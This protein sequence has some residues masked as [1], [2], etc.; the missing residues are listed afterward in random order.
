ML[1]E[2]GIAAL[3]V[4]GY[5]GAGLGGFYDAPIVY[6]PGNL[7]PLAH[8]IKKHVSVPVIAVGRISP[9]LAEE[10]LQDEKADFIAMGRPLLA[11]PMLPDKLASGKRDLVRPC[12][13]CYCCV[14]QIF[15]G[16]SIYCTVNPI[17]GNENSVKKN[18]TIYPRHIVVIGGGPAGIE[19]AITAARR[20]HKV[21]LYE[22]EDCLGGQFFIASLPPFKHDI[23][24]Y[25]RFCEHELEEAGVNVKLGTEVNTTNLMNENPDV[26]VI[27]TGGRPLVPDIPGIRGSN[28]VTAC[29]VISGRVTTGTNI[30]VAGGGLIGCEAADF[31]SSLGKN[32]TIV[33][34]LPHLAN[35]TVI[36]LRLLLSQ[37]LE[38]AE[39]NMLTSTKI[40]EFTEDGAI[41]EKDGQHGSISG[42]DNMVL[43]LG[44]EQANDLY[45]TATDIAAEV[46]VIGDA[47]SPGKARD[48]IYAGAQLGLQ[49]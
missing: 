7:L 47:K 27:A 1:E 37:R 41:V 34:M 18:S 15:W 43:A 6:P 36:W 4:S 14:S 28:V 8:E 44:T 9:E 49:V 38:R 40:I 35:D 39:V 3:H 21:T 24:D 30:L 12:I 25:L 31:L 2:A 11:D 20:G 13:M 29:D 32:V 42:M 33:E 48:A 23:G 16:E 26:I 5:G 17:V 22:R 46:F 19:A 45:E 10:A